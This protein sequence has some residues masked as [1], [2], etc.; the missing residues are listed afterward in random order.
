MHP[1]NPNI[2]LAGAGHDYWSGS[3]LSPGGAFLTEDGGT[4]WQQT[5]SQPIYSV[6]FCLSDPNIAYAANATGVY[7]NQDS[8]HTW[9]RMS[10]GGEGGYWRPSSVVAGFPIDI[11]YDPRDPDPFFINNYSGGNHRPGYLAGRP[12][13]LRVYE[14]RR[15]PPE[16]A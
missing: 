15:L 13:T 4:T 3:G 14:W 1:R 2:L 16:R 12:N 6:E 11:Q 7:R 8:G 10:G 5:L 9:E